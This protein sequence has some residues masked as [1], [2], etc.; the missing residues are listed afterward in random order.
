MRKRRPALLRVRIQKCILALGQT[1]FLS[2][3]CQK[4][5]V[6]DFLNSAQNQN[7]CHISATNVPAMLIPTRPGVIATA[8]DCDPAGDAAG[9]MLELVLP[10][11]GRGRGRDVGVRPVGDIGERVGSGAGPCSQWQSYVYTHVQ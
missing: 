4:V 8:P 11:A 6:T 3:G 7:D 10:A 1:T 9:A 2:M 5:E